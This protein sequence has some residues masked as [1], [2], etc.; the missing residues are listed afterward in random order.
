MKL[1]LALVAALA[2]LAAPAFAKGDKKPAADEDATADDSGD[3]SSD[4]DASDKKKPKAKPAPDEAD[5]TARQDKDFQKQDLSGHDLGSKKKDNEFERDRFFVDKADTSKL[6][7]TTL[8]QG[9]LSSSSFYYSES[10]GAYPNLTAGD[11]AAKF[12]RM[13]TE[14]RLQTDF[15][16]ISG[17]HWDARI[18]ARIRAVNDPPD[19][20]Y[21]VAN[22]PMA[23]VTPTHIQ[24]GLNG[25]NEY[26]LRELWLVRNGERSDVF[27]GR[28]FVPDL[29]AIKIDGLRIDYA[30][31]S[32]FTLLGFGGLYPERGSRSLSTD[33]PTLRTNQLDPAGKLVGALGG[34]A[35]YRTVDAYGAIGAV[36]LVPF[37]AETP[38]VYVT[39]NGYWRYGSQLD[40]YHYAIV[41]LV[42]NSFGTGTV[43]TN[44][45]VGLNYKPSPRLRMTASFNR[46]DTET[47]NVQ[48]NA[49]L[50]PTDTNLAAVQNETFIQR[51]STNLARV[52]ASAGLGQLQRFELSAAATYRYR[53]DVTL[54]APDAMGG[55]GTSF[56]LGA[57]KGIDLYASL[58]DRHSIKDLRLGVDL[59]RTFG[60]G[61]VA[62]Q[63]SEVFAI[64]FSGAHEIADGKGEWEAEVSYA[65]TKDKSAGI[66]CADLTTC[67]GASTGS[68]LSLGGN[69]YYRINHDWFAM[70][71]AFLSRQGLVHTDGTTLTTDPTITGLTGFF[72]IAYRF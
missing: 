13:F 59:S 66:N 35:A 21:L 29:G 44:L 3:D 65:T 30:S 18:D 38:R 42:N 20:N 47:L 34:G 68:I 17:G 53:P 64:R 2:G 11:D 63:R 54:T 46:V 8:V 71:S 36:A 19:T 1:A 51:L 33:Y 45:S 15:R 24:S 32:K 9:S 70:V 48:A 22:N 27:I 23:P 69:L 4:E 28:Q 55:P 5:D 6:Q 61:T 26:E 72:R 25:Q 67:Y 16:H 49:F 12:S 43:L 40:L 52:G 62:F 50:S 57:G 56:K 10:G 31:S 39:S 60:L 58:T 7:K 41:D 14:L 37:Q